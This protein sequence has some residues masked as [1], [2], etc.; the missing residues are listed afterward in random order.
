MKN[1]I[2][3]L[4]LA[5]LVFL[6]ALVGISTMLDDK[7]K[8]EDDNELKV[9][10]DSKKFKDEYEGY[11]GK[12]NSS[13][14]NT[15]LSISIAENNPMKYSNPEEIIKLLDGDT[16]VIYFGFPTCPWCRNAV[17]VLLE[18][19]KEKKLKTIYYYDLSDIKNTWSMVDGKAT[20]TK[21]EGEGYY[22]LLE[23]FDSI[24]DEYV[25]TDENGIEHGTGEDRI[26]NPLVIFV[27]D[28]K[29]IGHH[30]GTM[31]FNEGQTAYDQ[32]TDTQK[33]ALKNIYSEYMDEVLAADVC[34]E[35]CE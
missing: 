20:K 32:L 29:I 21:E 30:S 15:F 25:L 26:Y 9:T 34:D 4:I 17:P 23:A 18:V 10:E 6:V 8:N 7:K 24:I 3:K 16:G 19:A 28:G 31:P 13:G 14:T 33:T 5:V 1:N 12:Q 22:D 2:I 11:N 35:S 27:K